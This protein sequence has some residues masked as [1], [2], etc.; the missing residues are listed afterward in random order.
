MKIVILGAGSAAMIVADIV[1]ESHNFDLAGFIGTQEEEE[2]LRNSKIYQNRL[3]LGDYSILPKLREAEITGFIVAIGNNFRRERVYYEA[4][5]AGLMPVN[6]ISKHAII[7]PSV[8]LGRGNVVA[9]G[10]NLSHG[11]T[12]GDNVLIDASV[13]VFVSAEIGDHCRLRPGSLVC[14]SAT[15]EKNVQLGAGSIVESSIKVGK[16]QTVPAGAI[17]NEDLAGLYRETGA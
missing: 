6:A 11:V 4:M 10:V 1:M 8:T 12:I 5:Q 7:N 9:P 16:N 15:I 2:T 14:G 13:I 17:V 3:F